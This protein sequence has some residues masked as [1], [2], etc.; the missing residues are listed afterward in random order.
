MSTW[1]NVVRLHLTHWRTSMMLMWANMAAVFAVEVAIVALIRVHLPPTAASGSYVGGSAVI[2][3]YFLLFGV[4]GTTRALPFA[5]ALGVTRRAYYTGAA[6]L[7]I[8]LAAA[9]GLVLALLG[10]LERATGG[11]WL[12]VHMFRV[13]WILDGPWYLSWLTAFVLLALS[14]LYGM[15]LG[16]VQRRWGALILGALMATQAT[17]LVAAVLAITWAHAW[18]GVGRFFTDL[19]AQGLTGVLAGV[20]L[21][22]LA[23]GYG[24]IRRATV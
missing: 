13:P 1:R 10:V 18:A 14:F 21:L 9:N 5:L 6:V 24:T 8:G 3:V 7:A 15:W 17:V 22:L 19:T 11:W 4:L 23:G 20:A 16:L 12:G 2:F